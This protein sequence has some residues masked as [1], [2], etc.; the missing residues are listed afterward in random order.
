MRNTLN[1]E[2][3]LYH[4][5]RYLEEGSPTVENCISMKIILTYAQLAGN[6]VEGVVGGG[7]GAVPFAANVAD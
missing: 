5:K 7:G 3:L 2:L 4:T 6:G 1:V